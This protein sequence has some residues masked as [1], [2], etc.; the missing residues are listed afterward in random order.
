MS[1]APPSNST[2]PVHRRSI[3]YEAFD[4]GEALVVVGT[5]RDTRPWVEDPAVERVHDMELRVK[6]GLADFTITDADAVMHTFPHAEC[7]AIVAAFRGLV[8]LS[9][10]RGYTRAVQQRFG[11]VLGCT[12]LEHLARSLGPMVVQAAT[13]HMA[14]ARPAR[15]PDP[16]Q[17]ETGSTPLAIRNSCHI[18]AEDGIAEQKLALGWQ[19]GRDEYPAPALV[20]FRE[21]AAKGT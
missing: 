21:R 20:Y 1:V 2:V 14:W 12:H 15:R 13:S 19:P 8:G 18:W 3:E 6:V 9:V 4:A 11:G 16:G 17:A 7:P 10:A 5:L